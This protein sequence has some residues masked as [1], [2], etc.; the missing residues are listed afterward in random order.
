M[1][2]SQYA[3]QLGINYQ[4]AY[5][6]F[7]KGLIQGYQ[8]DTG[9]IIITQSLNNLNKIVTEDFVIYCESPL[10]EAKINSIRD[11]IKSK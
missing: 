3:K 6:W 7:K 5:R 8:M 11:I 9:T 10:S 2:L 4:T 1:K